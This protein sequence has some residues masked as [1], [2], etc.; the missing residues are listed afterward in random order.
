MSADAL[1]DSGNDFRRVVEVLQLELASG[2]VVLI[3]GRDTQR[4]DRIAC[5]LEGRDVR[6][7]IRFCQLHQ[8]RCHQ[9]P[10]LERGWDGGRG[11]T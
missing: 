11:V 10:M 4:L 8:F 1:S 2:D 9:C 3:K 5:A 7:E 6:C